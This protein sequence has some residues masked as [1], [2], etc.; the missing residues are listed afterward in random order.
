VYNAAPFLGEAVQSIVNQSRRDFELIVFND[1]S[2]DKSGRILE[3]FAHADSRLSIITRRNRGYSHCLNEGLALSRGEFV[4]RMDAD[5][6]SLPTRFDE[7]AKFLDEHQEVL[8]V[9]G[10]WIRI[11]EGG[12]ILSKENELPTT[13]SEIQ[14]EL[15][16]GYGVMPHPGVMMR[17]QAVLDVGCYRPEF[18]PAEDLDL[19][20][21]LSEIGELANLPDPILRYR[22]HTKAT[23]AIRRSEQAA[24]ALRAVVEAHQRRKLPVPDNIN[25]K[26]SRPATHAA[27]HGCAASLA[28]RSSVWR[29]AIKHALLQLCYAPATEASWSTVADLWRFFRAQKKRATLQRHL[30]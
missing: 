8:A 22:V 28:M 15:L 3:R 2:T 19:W 9:S 29:S 23:T 21:R 30:R 1:G 5:D 13:H 11:D 17:R 12:W 26:F 10:Q 20:L 24:A 25:P 6:I 16:K 18:E 7:Q 4:A 27:A 14:S